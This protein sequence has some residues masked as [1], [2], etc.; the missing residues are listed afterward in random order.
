MAFLC[1][2]RNGM[3]MHVGMAFLCTYRNGILIE[4][5][6]AFLYSYVFI[7]QMG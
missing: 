2:F 5:G 7:L 6:M 3:F 1:T 4:I